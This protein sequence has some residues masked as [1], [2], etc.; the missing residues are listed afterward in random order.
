MKKYHRDVFVITNGKTTQVVRV[1]SAEKID[2]YGALNA[3]A[4]ELPP[5]EINES[6][7]LKVYCGDSN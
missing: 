4:R 3:V 2:A 5:S 7:E 6:R 1:E